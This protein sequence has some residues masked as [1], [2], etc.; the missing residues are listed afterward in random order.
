MKLFWKSLEQ[1]DKMLH[2][3][4]RKKVCMGCFRKSSQ[5]LLSAQPALLQRV[6]DHLIKDV[7]V[8]DSRVPI[9]VCE[10]CRPRLHAIATKKE[11]KPFDLT[12]LHAYLST[13]KRI[14][15]RGDECTC[16]VC[17]LASSSGGAATKLLKQYKKSVGRPSNEPQKA[18]H[19]LC[20]LCHSPLYFGC[21]HA[22]NH[23]TLADNILN[24][25]SEGVLDQ[26]A[27]RHLKN[28]VESAESKQLFLKTY[29]T[30]L[31]VRNWAPDH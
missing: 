4:A 28:K 6:N 20:G 29:G 16:L 9:G 21:V 13:Q 7:D 1:P 14:S 2:E 5:N 17:K 3:D 30:P 8:H 22:C 12:N 31:P 15:P 10:S 19:R 11:S 18:I 27:S 23:T 26:I 24:S 25:C